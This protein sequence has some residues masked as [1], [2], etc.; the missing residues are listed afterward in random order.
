MKLS[1]LSCA[2]ILALAFVTPA[3]AATPSGGVAFGATLFD[4]QVDFRVFFERVA[5]FAGYV[6]SS[7]KIDCRSDLLAD[8]A[9]DPTQPRSGPTDIHQS[10]AYGEFTAPDGRP[11]AWVYLNDR[12]LWVVVDRERNWATHQLMSN[13]QH[14]LVDGTGDVIADHRIL[15]DLVTSILEGD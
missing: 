6:D 12:N 10:D 14:D 9:Y 15:E 8:C 5:V 13:Y 2:T 7:R 11:Y 3:R 1:I 4:R